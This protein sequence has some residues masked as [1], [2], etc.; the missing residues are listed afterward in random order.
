MMS[1]RKPLVT[2]TFVKPSSRNIDKADKSNDP[3]VKKLYTSRRNQRY[4]CEESG[5]EDDYV[6]SDGNKV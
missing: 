6:E 1:D 5:G 3:S 2:K 4:D